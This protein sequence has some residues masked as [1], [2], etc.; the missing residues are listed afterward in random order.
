[1]ERP[2]KKKYKHT[3]LV[4]GDALIKTAYHGASDL[5]YKG[6]HIG[7]LFQFFSLLRKV[8]TT[9]RF[10]RIFIFWDGQFSGRLRYDLYS[11]YKGNRDKDFYNETE[12]KDLDLFLQK[13][14]VKSTIRR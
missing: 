2:S 13:E 7:G 10:D 12:P 8:L 1:V 11:D 6:E 4:D 14:R 5:F 3:L 9:H